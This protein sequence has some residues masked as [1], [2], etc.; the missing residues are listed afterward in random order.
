MR[1][2]LK[3]SEEFLSENNLVEDYLDFEHSTDSINEEP[4][5]KQLNE[6]VQP[7]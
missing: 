4:E 1:E 3:H 7:N 5:V 6:G 2:N